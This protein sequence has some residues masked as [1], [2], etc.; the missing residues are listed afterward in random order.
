MK[1]FLVILIG[2]LVCAGGTLFAAPAVSSLRSSYTAGM[3][4][5]EY[6]RL[7]GT[8]SHLGV[9]LDYLEY[10]DSITAMKTNVYTNY[11]RMD[12]TNGQFTLGASGNL[13]GLWG[14]ALAQGGYL[15]AGQGLTLNKTLGN[16]N[17]NLTGTS[18]SREDPPTR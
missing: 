3:F 5:A 7:M 12:T 11:T 2:G 6:D 18:G 1:R 9:S 15:H 4:L 10:A 8:P 14:G 17:L 16:L 13:G